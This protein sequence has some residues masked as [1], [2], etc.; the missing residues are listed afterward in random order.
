MIGGPR[1]DLPASFIQILPLKEHLCFIRR[2]ILAG[3]DTCN[4]KFPFPGINISGNVDDVADLEAVFFHKFFTDNARVPLLLEVCQLFLR[5]GIFRIHIKD[6][7]GI[8]GNTRKEIFETLILECSLEP[9]R[10]RY[11]CYAG[12]RFNL[13]SV[14]IRQRKDE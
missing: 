13:T 8:H 10:E 7:F 14:R 12:N 5:N 11:L 3:I 9:V 1:S 4:D 2:F 6:R